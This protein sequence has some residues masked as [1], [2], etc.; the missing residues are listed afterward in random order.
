[1][2]ITNEEQ[3]NKANPMGT[4]RT[5]LGTYGNMIEIQELKNKI[6]INSLC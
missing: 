6:K 3:S 1:L 5:S 2:S 4:R